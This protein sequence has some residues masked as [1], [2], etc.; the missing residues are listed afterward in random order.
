VAI[1]HAYLI[2]FGVVQLGIQW[3]ILGSGGLFGSWI[4]FDLIGAVF[5]RQVGIFF[6]LVDPSPQ[7]VLSFVLGGGFFFF[8]ALL[9]LLWLFQQ[10]RTFQAQILPIGFGKKL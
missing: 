4:G 8:Y 7:Q 9:A 5:C 10:R 2:Y 1:Y 6:Q 3:V